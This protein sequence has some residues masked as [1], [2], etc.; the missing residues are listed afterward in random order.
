[1]LHREIE[2]RL[3]HFIRGLNTWVVHMRDA[4]NRPREFLRVLLGGV[5]IQL[6]AVGL[7][8]ILVIGTLGYIIIEGWSVVDA[9]YMT[10]ITVSTVGFGEVEALSDT[11]RLFTVVIIIL[12]LGIVTYG[13]S[14]AIEYIATG[15]VLQQM[16]EHQKGQILSKMRGHFIIAGFGRVGREVAAAF[17]RDRVPFVIVDVDEQALN[18]AAEMEFVTIRGSI[19]EDDTLKAAA[20]ERASGLVAC[21]GDDAINV[22]AVLSARG[23]NADLLIIARATDLGSQAKM[24]RAGANRVIS[25]YVL[26]GRRMAD[27]AVRP[28]VVDFLDLSSTSSEIEQSLEEVVVEDGSVIVNQT[29]GQVNLRQRTGANILAMYLPNGEWLSNPTAHTMLEPGTR[30]ILLG[31]RDQ[32]DVTETLAKSLASFNPEHKES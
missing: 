15:Q 7:L 27:L 29:I 17:Q 22:Y 8:L 14:S 1:M 25:P 3:F 24:I 21:A 23:L 5:Q 6:V 31:S 2:R 26:S 18:E 30:L 19:T 9:T 20:I 32:L 12:S 16:E 13:L 4:L 28:H 10:I 11:G